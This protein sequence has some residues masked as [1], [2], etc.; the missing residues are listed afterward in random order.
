MVKVQ[1]FQGYT[2]A[3]TTYD[4]LLKF[5]HEA[6]SSLSENKKSYIHRVK[7]TDQ[8]RTGMLQKDWAPHFYVYKQ[9]IGQKEMV[10]IMMESSIEDCL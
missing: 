6:L 5:D 1:A 9:K 10:G 4:T 7:T 8:I 3:S 2:Y